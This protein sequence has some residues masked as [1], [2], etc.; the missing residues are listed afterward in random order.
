MVTSSPPSQLARFRD[1]AL[2]AWKYGR[3]AKPTSDAL[4]DL[5]AEGG[6]AVPADS[7]AATGEALAADLEALGPTFVK[8][9]QVLATRADLLPI[10]YIEALARLQDKVAPFE[11]AEVERIVEAELGVRISKAFSSF[12][13]TPLAAASLGQ[14]HRAALRDGRLVVVKVQRPG[15]REIIAA[16]LAALDKIA[17]TLE[18]HTEAGRR[19]DLVGLV[20]EFRRSL[21]KELDY[22]LE[23][24]NLLRLGENLAQFERLTVPQPIDDYTTSSVLTMDYVRGRK[25][26]S[27]GPLTRIDIDATALAGELFHAYLHQVLVDGFFH[28][29][30]H[31]GNVF[32]TD[33]GR[34]ALLDL[35]MVGNVSPELQDRLLRLLLAASA[36]KGEEAAS[37]I[38]AIG[39]KL[40]D[41]DSAKLKQV[42]APLVAQNAGATIQQLAIGRLLLELS[43]GANGAGL[44]VPP[45]LALLGKT[46]LHLDEIGRCLDPDFDPNASIRL[47]AS[48]ITSERMRKSASPSHLLAALSE[49][50]DFVEQLPGRANKILDKVANN[51]LRV[52][53]DAIDQQLL[54]EGFQKVANRITVGLILAALIMGAAMLMNVSTSFRLLGYPGLAIVCFLGA[55]AGGVFLVLSILWNDRR[56]RNKPGRL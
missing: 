11:Y 23:A 54:M 13:P 40:P 50:K 7:P 14:V 43:H 9:G 42:V 17:A 31:P 25:L 52:K 27:I 4:A 18:R 1:I 53:V 20:A 46:L 55:A 36:G 35:G 37:A 30:P 8:L 21:V 19:Y 6:D 12:D 41:F 32:L 26:T 33:D 5:L 49:M 29:D 39:L 56:S 22:R 28:A 10:S 3:A 47:H 44:R 16:D 34:L 45:E 15:V 38:E 48:E 2:L 51:E 24:Q